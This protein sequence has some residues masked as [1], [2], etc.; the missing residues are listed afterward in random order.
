[1]GE[2]NFLHR[3]KLG[4]A[5][6]TLGQLWQVPTFL[7]GAL[8]FTVAAL[9]APLRR[10]ATNP[11]LDRAL[12]RLREVLSVKRDKLDALLPVADDVL[13][14][15]THYPHK[16]G[17]A[18]Y[19]T[20][21]LYMR[22]TDDQPM[23]KAAPLR[24]RALAHLEEAFSRG[25]AEPDQA[26]LQFRLGQLLY[27]K[28]ELRRAIPL[29]A[30]SIDQQP[31][32]QRPAAYG[33]LV[34]AY[35][36]LPRPD[37]D[38]ALQV[39][40]KQLDLLVEEH[41]LGQAWL[42]RGELQL[43]KERRQEALKTL[44]NIGAKAPRELRVPARLLQVRCCEEEGLWNKAIELWTELMP[45]AEHV[46]GGRARIL[47]ALGWCHVNLDQPDHKLAQRW[48]EEASGLD[49][50]E[51]QAA[52]LRLGELWLMGPTPDPASALKQ[53]ARALERVNTPEDYRND[54][55]AIAQL[56]EC[57]DHA[58]EKYRNDLPSCQAL[59]E[60]YKRVALPG[61]AQECLARATE[62]M[63]QGLQQRAQ[64]AEKGG[65]TKMSAAL[66]QEAW[67]E[68]HR[69]AEAYEQAAEALADAQRPE[70]LWRSAH[71]YL[72]AADYPKAAAVLER[73]LKTEQADERVAEG[74][75]RL[76]DAYRHLGDK[77]KAAESYHAC[78]AVPNTPFA[79]R[80]LYHMALLQASEK[81]WDDAQHTLQQI[82][83]MSIAERDTKE[84][85]LFRLADVLLQ[86]KDYDK[87]RLFLEQAIQQY[88][89][90]PQIWKMRDQL[91]ECYL[92]LAKN[93][94]DKLETNPAETQYRNNRR[95]WLKDAGDTFHQLGEDLQ[96]YA[97]ELARQGKRLPATE[98]TLYRRANVT[99]AIIA[100]EL[101]DY[102]QALR[103]FER[104]A[105]GYRK[106]HEGLVASQYMYFCV[107]SMSV[108]VPAEEANLLWSK[109]RAVVQET[110]NDI[111]ALPE[112]DAVFTR[113]PRAQWLSGFTA[114]LNYVPETASNP[115]LTPRPAPPSN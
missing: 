27:Q 112:T 38:A 109:M 39:N 6:R 87:A 113:V 115:N 48:W 80:A 88:P 23:D 68:Y 44:A 72:S 24:A 99:L 45:E 3:T 14:Q 93:L 82:L 85:A 92:S 42:L 10:E 75:L 86:R 17:E 15:V 61:V 11:E 79:A 2:S 56:R 46:P 50:V 35:L 43:K 100:F 97:Q 60:L 101:E 9:S 66:H 106:Q 5:S 54:L 20:G 67:I 105:L 62:E 52:S 95:K 33:M 13:M 19:L 94:K 55:L 96:K 111:Q 30:R 91:G 1:M 83:A 47:Y 114:I 71:C 53:L 59:A 49:G 69:A 81:Q 78:I 90:N 110:L 31:L 22:I 76:A 21:T 41:A 63:A 40:Q 77:N 34:Q 29:L 28:G 70:A 84:L 57:F 36:K 8:A 18:H 98:M 65:P 89:A 25:V 103:Q 73:F 107:K 26:M 64:E 108:L 58:L 104:L 7:I 74:R 37:I 32:E 12:S 102:H 51:A 4:R 16:S